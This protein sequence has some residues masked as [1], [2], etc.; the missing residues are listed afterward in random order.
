VGSKHDWL[1]LST[2]PRQRRISLTLPLEGFDA[3]AQPAIE[4]GAKLEGRVQR[5]ERFGVFVWL[6]PGRVGLMPNVATGT[7]PGTDLSRQFPVGDPVKV[8][9]TEVSEDGR[10]IRL[11][12]EGNK[13]KGKQ[14]KERERTDDFSTRL[15][16]RRT[17]EASTLVHDPGSSF[18]TSLADKLKAALDGQD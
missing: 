11:G 3:D 17:H 12:V 8:E 10:R 6:G 2:E 1:V 7:R 5:I 14:S 9:V 15:K 16:G 4:V 18:G 13:P